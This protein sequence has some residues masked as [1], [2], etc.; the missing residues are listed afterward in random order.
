MTKRQKRSMLHAAIMI[1]HGDMMIRCEHDKRR[2]SSES[3]FPA[4]Y[5]LQQSLRFV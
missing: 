3:A 4:P 1:G 2:G 5:I